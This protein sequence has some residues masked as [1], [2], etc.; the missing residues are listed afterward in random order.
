LYIV[1]VMVHIKPRNKNEEPIPTDVSNDGEMEVIP[2]IL[3]N[4]YEISSVRIMLPDDLTIKNNKTL[5]KETMKEVI[6]L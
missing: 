1:D 3:E 4:I 2:M 6:Y 5:V